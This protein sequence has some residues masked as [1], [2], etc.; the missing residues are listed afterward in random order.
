MNPKQKFYTDVIKIKLIHDKFA[1]KIKFTYHQAHAIYTINI[2]WKQFHLQKKQT[3]AC[4]THNNATEE[5]V[6]QETSNIWLT[7]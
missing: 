7:E 2:E 6:D 4:D 1:T 5:P 3:K